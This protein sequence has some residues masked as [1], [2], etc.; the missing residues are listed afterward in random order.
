MK[1]PI[2]VLIQARQSSSR[3]PS[4]V[5]THFCGNMKMI[6]FQYLR[7]KEKFDNVTVA[8]S[9][10]KSDNEMCEYLKYKGINYYRGSLNNVMQRLIDC[11]EIN[12]CSS[13][14]WFVR[15]GGDDP[16]VS[17]EG[18]ELMAKQIEEDSLNKNVAM[19]YSSYDDGMI[20]GC[21]VELFRAVKYREILN[22][23]NRK[24]TNEENK[25]DVF[26]E[27]TKPAF[28]NERILNATNSV[29]VRAKIPE[30]YK[31]KQTYLSIDYGEDFLIASYI[32]NNLYN[33]YGLNFSHEQL[34][35][36]IQ[37]TNNKLLINR[38]LHDGFGE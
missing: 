26:Q 2:P 9:I 31:L 17:T 5:M 34:I 22:Y 28:T 18:I 11:Y 29:K 38:H 37:S 33:R 19:Y 25:K 4:K 10:D 3:L 16:L 36:C 8:T 23:V 13:D 30:R 24:Q 35:E 21:A 20:Y 32:A 15:V 12:A 14:E 1:N 6:E 27:H 7:L